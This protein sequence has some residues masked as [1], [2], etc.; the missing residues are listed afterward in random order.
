MLFILLSIVVIY[1]ST[2]SS[3]LLLG[4]NCVELRMIWTIL[5][6]RIISTMCDKCNELRHKVPV[7][8]MN[9]KLTYFLSCNSIT[10][11]TRQT[12]NNNPMQVVPN[13][14]SSIPEQLSHAMEI[15]H[16]HITTFPHRPILPP[17]SPP[18]LRNAHLQPNQN[19]SSKG[20]QV[21]PLPRHYINESK[22]H[23]PFHYHQ[24]Y[25]PWY[26]QI[27]V[28]DTIKPRV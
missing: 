3:S 16:A 5:D 6:R 14:R 24:L 13:F 15:H 12:I 22:N 10:S 2:L 17:S 9:R 4:Y 28:K 19:T 20:Q 26:K 11:F 1:S 8:R 21:P 27:Y 25:I 18:S 7:Y 23:T